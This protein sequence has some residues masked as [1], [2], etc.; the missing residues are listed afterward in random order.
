MHPVEYIV[1]GFVFEMSNDSMEIQYIKKIHTHN[2]GLNSYW[3]TICTPF[4]M[5][6]RDGER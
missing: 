5:I 4:E 2:V 6:A 1:C 3:D